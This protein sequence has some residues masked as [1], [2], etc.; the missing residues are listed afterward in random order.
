MIHRTI[1]SLRKLPRHI[2]ARVTKHL[3][4]PSVVLQELGVSE[5]DTLLELGNPVGFFAPA[6]V[7]LVGS[8]GRVIVAGPNEDSFDRIGHLVEQRMIEPVLL[9]DVLLGRAFDHHS[10]DLVLLTNLLSSSLHPNQFCLS[11]GGYL[12]FDA[13]IVLMDWEVHTG[14]GPEHERKVSR[15]DAIRMLT[16][17]GWKFESTLRMP[18]YHYGLVFRNKPPVR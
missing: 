7:S 2:S 17:C 6:A 15:E 13:R 16:G 11:L 10:V 3:L 8:P 1:H 9:A 12:K 18:G 5:G 4:S 14:V